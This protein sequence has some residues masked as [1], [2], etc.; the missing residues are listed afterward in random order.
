MKKITGMLI[1][2]TTGTASVVTIDNELEAF[3]DILGCQWIEMP[4]RRIGTR[5]G[6]NFII[7]CDEEG[8]LHDDPMISAIDHMGQPMLVGNLFIVKSD[9]LDDILSLDQND[10]KYLQRFILPQATNKHPNPYLMLHQ[11]EYAR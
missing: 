5:N 10:I 6:R 4:T 2:V 8:L 9:G 11:C 7:I 3:Y 1:D